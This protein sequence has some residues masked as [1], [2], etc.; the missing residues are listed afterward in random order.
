MKILKKGNYFV[1]YRDENDVNTP[2]GVG[3]NDRIKI[4]ESLGRISIKTEK[5][6]GNTICFIEL[7]RHLDAH[8]KN[9]PNL[10]MINKRDWYARIDV[11]VPILK[12]LPNDGFVLNLGSLTILSDKRNL[13]LDTTSTDF[14]NRQNAG[15][16]FTLH[17]RL[18]IDFDTFPIDEENNYCVKVADI[19]SKNFT[20]SLFLSDQDL[21]VD[22]D[23]KY[24]D[25]E[26]ATATITFY[27]LCGEVITKEIK[28]EQ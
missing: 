8:L 26:N 14:K 28:L 23:D 17:S 7:S 2:D 11:S 21:E 22:D 19:L 18:E 15:E 10:K 12:K 25:F 9:D 16:T 3:M 20:G 27:D 1:A 6:V 24:F 13:I 5:F 4:G